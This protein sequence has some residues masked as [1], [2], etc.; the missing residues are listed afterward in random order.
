ML[1]SISWKQA[2]ANH[3]MYPPLDSNGWKQTDQNTLAVDWDSEDNIVTI[4][5]MDLMMILMILSKKWTR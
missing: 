5:L 3:I 1:G 2:T 4:H